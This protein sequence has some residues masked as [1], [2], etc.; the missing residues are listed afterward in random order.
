MKYQFPV[1]D[2][3]QAREVTDLEFDIRDYDPD[4]FVELETIRSENPFKNIDYDLN[5]D[6][7]K[8]IL[9]RISDKYNKILFS[10]HRGCGKTLELN[11]YYNRINRPDNYFTIFI[12]IEKE[13]EISRFEASDIFILL[14]VSLIKKLNSEGIVIELNYLKD[15]ITEWT[16]DEEIKNELSSS[17]KFEVGAETS[18]GANFFGFLKLS[19]FFKALFASESKIVKTIREK[20]KRNI[21]IL[22]DKFNFILNQ[23]REKI[24]ETNKGKDI[25]FIIDG[26][27]K[28]PFEKYKQIFIQD[29]YLIRSI[30]VNMILS[31]PIH[32]CFD[33]KNNPSSEFF[34]VQLLPMIRLNNE[35]KKKFG[36]IIT[37]RIDETTFFDE[38]VLDKCIEKSGG[39]PRQ[40]LRIV[41]KSLIE[42]LGNKITLEK[43]NKALNKLGNDLKNPLDS[44]HLKVINNKTYNTADTKCLDLLFSLAILK[45]NGDYEINPL[46]ADVLQ[47]K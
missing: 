36:E 34:S 21:N 6:S 38:G 39:C 32:S 2:K 28:I 13:M 29:V 27:E 46:L 1:T 23:V 30:N 25:L 35:N 44:E 8:N 20:I 33:I 43:L 18:A 5:I 41:N 47:T 10:G 4:L 24:K 7:D 14:L 31:I 15:L 17:Y 16:S 40:L 22:I 9:A 11:K 26:S 19:S 42:S 12:E 3:Y 45:Y 37:K